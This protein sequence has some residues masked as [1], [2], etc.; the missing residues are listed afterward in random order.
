MFYGGGLLYILRRWSTVC[1]MAVV[2][3]MFYGDGLL[4]QYVLWRWSTVYS[5]AVVFCMF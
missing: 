4:L 3:C 2:F 1:S 5:V